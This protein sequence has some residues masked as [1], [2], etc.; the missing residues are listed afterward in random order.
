MWCDHFG[1]G[2]ETAGSSSDKVFL[3]QSEIQLKSQASGEFFVLQIVCSIIT[4]KLQ[5]SFASALAQWFLTWIICTLLSLGKQNMIILVTLCWTHEHTM[6]NIIFLKIGQVQG[7]Q[8]NLIFNS[9]PLKNK[10]SRE[11]HQYSKFWVLG[12]YTV[13]TW[14]K[15]SHHS[16]KSPPQLICCF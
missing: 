8:I 12:Y 10:F 13:P 6:Q 7:C 4:L 16:H 3:N 11:N 5:P 9:Y 2:Y 1:K 14:Y 15:I